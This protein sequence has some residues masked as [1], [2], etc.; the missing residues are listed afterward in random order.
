[1]HRHGMEK[2]MLTVISANSDASALYDR[3]GYVMD[4]SSPS[5]CDAADDCGYEI[6][7]KRLPPP[8]PSGKICAAV[9]L[10]KMTLPSGF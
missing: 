7:C 8:P 9:D 10:D 3:L 4:E 2:V 1:M 5:A 6:L